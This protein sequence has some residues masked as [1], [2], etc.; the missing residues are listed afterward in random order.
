[1]N[2]DWSNQNKEFKKLI[3]REVT[4]TDGIKSL[5]ELRT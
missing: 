2:K 3:S 5:L 4:F 1:M